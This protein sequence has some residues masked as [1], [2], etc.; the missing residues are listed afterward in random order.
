MA[1]FPNF[2]HAPFPDLANQGV[3]TDFVLCFQGL[4]AIA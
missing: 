1:C 4:S 3:L 2:R